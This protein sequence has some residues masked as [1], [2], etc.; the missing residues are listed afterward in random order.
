MRSF[1]SHRSFSF[2]KFIGLP[3]GPKRTSLHIAPV[4][5]NLSSSQKRRKIREVSNLSWKKEEKRL[6]TPLVTGTDVFKKRRNKG[7]TFYILS[8]TL[9]RLI[10]LLLFLS[11][12]NI[13]IFQKNLYFDTQNRF[14]HDIYFIKN[15]HLTLN[16]TTYIVLK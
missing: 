11:Y 1:P 12:Y 8:Y 4:Q 14:I 16:S 5:E 6:K 2:I 7:Q 13:S 10:L 9:H 3:S 15:L